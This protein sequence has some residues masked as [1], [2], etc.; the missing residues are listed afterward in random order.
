MMP[1]LQSEANNACLYFS[2]N[3]EFFPCTR[4]VGEPC[5]MLITGG[6]LSGYDGDY[7]L[8]PVRHPSSL[9]IVTWQMRVGRYQGMPKSH[10]MSE[11]YVNSSPS[12]LKAISNAFL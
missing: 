11:S 4:L 3:F 6:R 8:L 12:S 5:P 10:S 9:T 1:K 7:W 2:G